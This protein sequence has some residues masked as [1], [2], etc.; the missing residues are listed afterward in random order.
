VPWLGCYSGDR[1]RKTIR[2]VSLASSDE[3]AMAV[4]V[5]VGDPT[6][7]L[8]ATGGWRVELLED[9]VRPSSCWRCT[10]LLGKIEPLP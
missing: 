8:L 6:A 9:D 10:C 5:L 7:S 4:C 3:A 2:S 1:E